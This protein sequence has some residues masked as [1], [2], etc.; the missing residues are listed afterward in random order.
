M[1][2]HHFPQSKKNF[3][4]TEAPK[5][6]SALMMIPQFD[7]D[8]VRRPSSCRPAW[9]FAQAQALPLLLPRT[10]ITSSVPS[11]PLGNGPRTPRPTHYVCYL[12]EAKGGHA[13]HVETG[14][15]TPPNTHSSE[16]TDSQNHSLRVIAKGHDQVIKLSVSASRS[17]D[18]RPRATPPQVPHHRPRCG[19]CGGVAL[20]LFFPRCRH[21]T[22]ICLRKVAHALCGPGGPRSIPAGPLLVLTFCINST[23]A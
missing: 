21:L 17:I 4:L 12:P 1:I 16:A 15:F 8:H 9:H 7:S 6:A 2:Y 19:T 3:K 22:T 11:V 23:R 14:Q 18:H 10:L 13:L 5:G 20:Y